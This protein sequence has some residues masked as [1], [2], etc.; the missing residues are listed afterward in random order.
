MQKDPPVL[1]ASAP[2]A[3]DA[4]LGGSHQASTSGLTNNETGPRSYPKIHRKPSM[5]KVIL[6]VLANK[7]K[8]SR[9]S[10][11]TLKKAVAATG[12]NMARNTGRFK[13]A[14]TKLVDKGM[15][16]QV[17]GKGASGSFRLSRK[18]A[19]K[20][21]LKGKRQQQRRKSGQRRS[22]QPKSLLSSTEGQKQLI[23]G[24]RRVAKCSHN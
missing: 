5:S 19:S 14:L 16:K 11:A 23:K 7:G 12:Y 1:P 22:R 13:L 8:R 10:Q 24:V 15:L 6:G 18:Q 2:L 9:V 4:S 17:T 3:S 21:K 20:F